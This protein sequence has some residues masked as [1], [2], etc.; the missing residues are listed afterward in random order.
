MDS[1]NSD[2][3]ELTGEEDTTVRPL[4]ESLR[5]ALEAKQQRSA[6]PSHPPTTEKS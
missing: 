2:I 4:R 5:K 1:L 6:P 3:L